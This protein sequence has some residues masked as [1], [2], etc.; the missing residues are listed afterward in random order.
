M[1]APVFD[2]DCEGGERCTCRRAE[3]LDTP[4]ARLIAAA[5]QCVRVW[6]PGRD[7]EGDGIVGEMMSALRDLD[8]A[9]IDEPVGITADIVVAEAC[10]RPGC[11][12]R[13]RGL[14]L[15]PAPDGDG[16]GWSGVAASDGSDRGVEVASWDDAD[17][18]G[19][20]ASDTDS[21]ALRDESE[22]DESN[23]AER[24]DAE[25]LDDGRYPARFGPAIR[26][27]ERILGRPAPFMAVAGARGG[28]VLNAAFSEW[29]MGFPPGWT[30][31]VS[32]TARLRLVGNAVQPQV[33]E[34]AFRGLRERLGEARG[35]RA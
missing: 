6:R 27:W 11:E 33:A 31:G 12:W 16:Y 32:R 1:S 7:S 5:R 30:E 26:R 34:V 29:M 10:G 13:E 15:Q 28:S 3:V 24:W 8:A 19:V 9:Y 4:T 17:G 25:P 2:P 35:A 14:A 21:D 18:R 22:R 23:E 20:H